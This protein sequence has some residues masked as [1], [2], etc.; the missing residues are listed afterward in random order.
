MN[1]YKKAKLTD[2]SDSE[3]YNVYSACMYC[4]R[5]ATYEGDNEPDGS[6]FVWKKDE[7]LNEEEKIH[8]SNARLEMQNGPS[9][10]PDTGI[11]HGICPYCQEVIHEIG[12]WPRTHDDIQYIADKSLSMT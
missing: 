5:W 11:S 4:H 1:W 9:S 7:E 10:N 12:G 2:K 3:T 6:Q 8:A